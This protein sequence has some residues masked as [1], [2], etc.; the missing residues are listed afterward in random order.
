ME[1]ELQSVI[2]IPLLD[3]DYKR[4]ELW[5]TSFS[6]KPKEKYLVLSPSGFGKSTLL[7]MIYGI[8]SDYEGKVLI[9]HTDISRF[10]RKSWAQMRTSSLS[11]VFQGLQLFDDLTALENIEIKNALTHFKS[12]QQI[13]EMCEKL[14]VSDFLPKKVAKLSYGQKQRIAIIRA[15]C[16]PFRYLLL[17]EPFSHLDPENTQFA[18]QL[19]FDEAAKQ[20]A[21][22]ITTS[23]GNGY[24]GWF[25]TIIRL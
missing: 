14:H 24:N 22:I 16:Q 7:S 5:G 12:S 21:G 11:I 8:R 1:I 25:Q 6:F 4:S 10:N 9:D 18:L 23:V 13:G 17:D 20:E 2:P 19:I 3:S 15:M